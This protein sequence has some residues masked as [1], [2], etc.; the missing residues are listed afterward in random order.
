M[1]VF[2]S[3]SEQAGI[4]LSE[5]VA[6]GDCDLHL[7]THSS[8][9]SDSA[10][11]LV[12]R[13]LES[14]LRAFAITDHDTISGIA[15]AREALALQT[16]G[17][18]PAANPKLIPG[19]EISV[20]DGQEL[21]LLGYFPY[22]GES[23]LEPFLVEQR[24]QRQARNEAL[25]LRL[26]E[27]GYSIDPGAFAESGEEV[28]GRMQIALL[29]VD[30]GYFAS[31]AAAFN[32]LLGEDKPGYM[33]RLRPTI[34]EAIQAIR[35]ANGAAVL[36]HPALYGWCGNSPYIEPILI[37]KLLT[38]KAFGLQGVEAFHGEANKDQQEQIEAA[39]LVCGLIATCGSDDHGSHKEHAHL[40]TRGMCPETRDSVVV[41]AA[42]IRGKNAAGEP[43]L[44]MTRRAGSRSSVGLWEYPGGKLES[45]ESPEAC[46][47]RELHEELRSEAKVGPLVTALYHDYGKNRVILLCY[48]TELLGLPM[49]DPGIHDDLRY[50]S[51]EE[52][53]SINILPA[54]L[55]VV[56][57]LEKLKY[58]DNP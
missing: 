38:Y 54:D 51:Y 22:G 3:E 26:A 50:F 1:T 40:Y 28:R 37:E 45:A 52:A 6:A 46:L 2:S 44:L 42:L 19:V 36:A 58:L 15:P 24:E 35:T 34:T 33:E 10:A 14:G 31:V 57:R 55:H 56:D 30:S 43:G 18:D 5:I 17:K 11:V 29:L 49:L 53:R 41:A 12:E 4:R 8:D 16:A 27:L 32:Q 25:L 13:V 39:A 23:A 21:H 47:A 7:H 20:E 9:G 48:E